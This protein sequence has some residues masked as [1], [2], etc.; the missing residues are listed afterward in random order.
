MS[1][2][3]LF[4]VMD[5]G[6]EIPVAH[7]SRTLTSAEKNYSQLEKEGL[8]IV[9]GVKKFHNYLFGRR[10]VIESDDQPLSYLFNETRG[11]SQCHPEFRGELV[12]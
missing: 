11:I 2:G 12:P 9:F 1:W 4:H 8:A 6:K 7:A 5:D 3:L 10:F